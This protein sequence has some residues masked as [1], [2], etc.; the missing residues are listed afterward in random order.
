[1]L[2]LVGSDDADQPTDSAPAMIK[3][4]ANMLF[5]NFNQDFTSVAAVGLPA[6]RR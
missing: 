5:A 6:R 3:A 4:N 2:E 1:L